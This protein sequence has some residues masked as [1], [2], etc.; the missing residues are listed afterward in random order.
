MFEWLRKRNLKK[1]VKQALHEAKHARN[2]REDV[3]PASALGKMDEASRRLDQISKAGKWD[4]IKAAVEALDETLPAVYGPMK[5]SRLREN[6]EVLVVAVAVAFAFRTY[7]IQP[8]KIPTGSMQPTLYGITMQPPSSWKIM[9]MR[10]FRYINYALFGEKYTEITSPGN[11]VI[12]R[13][14]F[15]NELNNEPITQMDH[16]IMGV[17]RDGR[18]PVVKKLDSP[19]EMKFF[20]IQSGDRGMNIYI[21]DPFALHVKDGDHVTRGQVLASGYIQGGDHIFVNKMK[22]NFVRPERGDIIVFDTK[23]IHYSGIRT[24]T[25]YIKRLA[26]LPGETIGINHPEDPDNIAERYLIADGQK[27]ETPY[28]FERLLTAPGYYGYILPTPP[29]GLDMAISTVRNEVTLTDEQFLPLGDNTRSSLDGRYFGGVEKKD[30]LGPAFAVYW[31]F[32][33]R[34]GLVK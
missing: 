17:K 8:F 19:T 15:Y 6:I 13:V 21:P 29:S 26:G 18:T 31:P 3:A 34:W 12:R 22:Y 27:I 28:P 9:N 33:R 2:M 11:G 16:L 32:G 1:I 7:F 24:N 30:L 14:S 25:F 23:D 10:P 4:E 20:Q 5:P